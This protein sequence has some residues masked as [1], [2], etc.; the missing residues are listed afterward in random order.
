MEAK[1]NPYESPRSAPDPQP[2]DSIWVSSVEHLAAFQQAFERTSFFRRHL[3][4]TYDLPD[5]FPYLRP[6]LSHSR[7]PL[8]F[9]AHG[10]LCISPNGLVFRSTPFTLPLNVVRNIDKTLEFSIQSSEITAIEPYE[11]LSPVAHLFDMV[12]ARVRTTN[13]N[14]QLSD[15]LI[16]VTT[17]LPKMKT[18]RAENQKL[19]NAIS[20][21]L[22]PA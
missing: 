17:K 16:S 8:I 4:G 9:F 6:F 11:F 1:V 14:S 3:L 20:S 21:E 19:V 2:F 10:C 7:I 5:G 15:I 12:F 22:I 18:L 13:V